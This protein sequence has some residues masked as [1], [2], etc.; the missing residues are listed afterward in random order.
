MLSSGHKTLRMN[1]E[2]KEKSMKEPMSQ[3]QIA[4][5]LAEKNIRPSLQRMA[6]YDFLVKNPVHPT[7]ETIYL[8]LSPSMPTLSR[9]T[10]YNT[11]KQFSECNLV[12]TVTIE[13]GELRYDAETSSHMHFKCTSCGTVFDIFEPVAISPAVIPEGF[14]MQKAQVNIWGTC[15]SCASSST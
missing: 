14:T 9:T 1:Q 8:A 10:I 6:I 12:Q 2:R 11:L 5:K 3:E 15:S 4:K 13:N 7:A